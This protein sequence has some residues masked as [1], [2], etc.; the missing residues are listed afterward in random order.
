[1]YIPYMTKMNVTGGSEKVLHKYGNFAQTSR[2]VAGGA[3]WSRVDLTKLTQL[4][5][6]D[7]RR[8]K[9]FVYFMRK[10]KTKNAV[11]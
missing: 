8:K 7:L 1:M 11:A 5:T 10:M 4:N 6:S 9:R 2:Q 3:R